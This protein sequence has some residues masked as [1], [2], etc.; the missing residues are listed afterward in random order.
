M[1]RKNNFYALHTLIQ[2]KS[3]CVHKY[4]SIYTTSYGLTICQTSHTAPLYPRLQ[5][6]PLDTRLILI[7]F[8]TMLGEHCIARNVEGD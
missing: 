1:H 6:W 8:S 4:I 3:T 2:Y 7:S 5:G